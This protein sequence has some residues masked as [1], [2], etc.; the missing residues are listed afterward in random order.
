MPRCV[1]VDGKCGLS[2][3]GGAPF[4]VETCSPV[5]DGSG[6][7]GCPSG[8]VACTPLPCPRDS[9]GSD[10]LDLGKGRSCVSFN[11]VYSLPGVRDL[12]RGAARSPCPFALGN[13]AAIV[14]SVVLAGSAAPVRDICGVSPCVPPRI[15]NLSLSAPWLRGR[16]GSD[17]LDGGKRLGLNRARLAL[18]GDMNEALPLELRSPS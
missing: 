1:G 11:G 16:S 12:R 4:V 6:R 14:L 7:G 8:F 10:T 18:V 2:L 15:L 9:A 5:R 3:A 17:A 13:G